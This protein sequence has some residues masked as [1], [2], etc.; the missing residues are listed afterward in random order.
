MRDN[1]IFFALGREAVVK[2]QQFNE[3][4]REFEEVE[5]AQ[6]PFTVGVYDKEA[7]AAGVLVRPGV[8]LS[9][10]EIATK[11]QY[12]LESVGL[13]QQYNMQIV[14][15]PIPDPQGFI[16][17]LLSASRV[18]RFEFDFSVPNPPD[19][20][21]FVQRPLKE[22]EKRIGATEGKAVLEGPS[23][24][25][26]ELVDLTRA[27]AAEGDHQLSP[28]HLAAPQPCRAGRSR[29]ELIPSRGTVCGNWLGR[30]D[31]HPVASAS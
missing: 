31:S 9:R 6:T 20:E 11:V 18:T 25:A 13:A 22:H 8:S 12:L 3:G 5:Q 26:D 4:R 17:I 21:K 29:S 28:P 15:D 16:E 7:K 14:V 1:G 10:R 27:V 24:D 2:S 19:D 23:L 30:Q